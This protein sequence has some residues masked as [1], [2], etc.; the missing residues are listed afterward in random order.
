MN[1]DVLGEDMEVREPGDE[2]EM[3]GL[4]QGPQ[5]KGRLG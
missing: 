1:S 2:V 5:W 3:R 4:L